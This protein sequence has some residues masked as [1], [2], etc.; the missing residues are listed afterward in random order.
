FA[1]PL[2]LRDL[3]IGAL[4]LVSREENPMNEADVLVARAFADLATI[5]VVQQRAVSESQRVNEQLNKALTSRVVIEQ[6]KGAVFER[7]GV[8]QLSSPKGLGAPTQPQRPLAG[9]PQIP[10]PLRHTS[11]R[12]EVTHALVLEQIHGYLSHL[13]CL[14]TANLKYPRAPDTQAEASGQRHH[15]VEDVTCEPARFLVPAFRRRHG[16]SGYEYLAQDPA[17][18]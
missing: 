5:S 9:H 17:C 7:L 18:V 3:T 6:A 14:A 13:A 8:G 10:H 16:W 2:R 11:R 15:R 12:H 4:N 1:L